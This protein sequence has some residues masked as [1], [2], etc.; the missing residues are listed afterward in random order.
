MRVE[1]NSMLLSPPSDHYWAPLHDGN[2]WIQDILAS[3][4]NNR[5]KWGPHKFCHWFGPSASIFA[6]VLIFLCYL[7]IH[8][9]A[10]CLHLLCCPRN[11]VYGTNQ[12]S[13]TVADWFG[14]CWPYH[15]HQC[16]WHSPRSV[17]W[18]NPTVSIW[19]RFSIQIPESLWWGWACNGS[20]FLSC[21]LGATA[22]E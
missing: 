22:V 10:D 20:E 19:S 2:T 16:L 21:P 13:V 18:W 15:K 11:S 5:V 1:G 14:F 3:F 17:S 6:C 12:L 9:R 4:L 8:R 7:F